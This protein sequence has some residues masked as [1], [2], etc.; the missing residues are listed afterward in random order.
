MLFSYKLY[1]FSHD[2]FTT[3]KKKVFL[4]KFL[5]NLLRRPDFESLFESLKSIF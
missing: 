3:T 5:R 1:N 2:L 4:S